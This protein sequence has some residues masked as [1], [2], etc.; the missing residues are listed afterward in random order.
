MIDVRNEL[1]IAILHGIKLLL[2]ERRDNE[3]VEA[4]KKYAISTIKLADGAKDKI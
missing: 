2:D 1:L 3:Q 4:Y